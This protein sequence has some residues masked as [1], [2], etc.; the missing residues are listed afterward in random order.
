MTT[1]SLFRH[2]VSKVANLNKAAPCTAASATMHVQRAPP[3]LSTPTTPT[4]SAFVARYAAL[5]ALT[6]MATLAIAARSTS[7][8]TSRTAARVA[9]AA[10]R[11]PRMCRRRKG[12][13]CRACLRTSCLHAF[14]EPV[15]PR[16]AR[17]AL[18][19]VTP[20]RPTAARHRSS[21]IRRT[22]D[23]VRTLARTQGSIARRCA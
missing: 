14:R 4:R 12:C 17:E 1:V 22:V 6:A 5:A 9:R 23:R 21:L 16:V 13:T 10:S 15:R 3:V 2:R 11:L 20:T 19:T 18:T 8:K 7:C